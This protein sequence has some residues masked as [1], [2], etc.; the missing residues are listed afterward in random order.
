MRKLTVFF[1]FLYTEVYSSIGNRICITLV[2][3]CLDHINHSVDLL[4]C[5]RMCGSRFYV[6]ACHVLLALCDITL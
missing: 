4:C 3:Q 2:D 1:E 6:H 5:K